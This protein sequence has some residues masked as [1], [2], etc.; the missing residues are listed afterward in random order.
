MHQP[1]A[2][3]TK[4]LDGGSETLKSVV[5]EWQELKKNNEADNSSLSRREAIPVLLDNL[6]NQ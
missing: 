6:P 5:R 4:L 3:P 2:S 1:L